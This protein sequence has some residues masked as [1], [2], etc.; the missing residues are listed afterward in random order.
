MEL[1]VDRRRWDNRMASPEWRRLGIRRRIFRSDRRLCCLGN[2]NIFPSR[3]RK[4]R[5]V[6][7]IG[8][9]R[10]NHRTDPFERGSNRERNPRTTYPNNSADSCTV[11]LRWRF[12]W[13]LHWQWQRPDWRQCP[14]WHSKDELHASGRNRSREWINRARLWGWREDFHG[15]QVD[16]KAG[17]SGVHWSPRKQP[18][19]HQMSVVRGRNGKGSNRHRWGWHRGRWRCTQQCR[20]CT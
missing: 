13:R 4:C 1:A 5:C 11:P 14:M 7:G 12:Q 17:Q 9:E 20:Q 10:R 8:K 3:H 6:R 2:R 16:P 19:A 15:S 18:K